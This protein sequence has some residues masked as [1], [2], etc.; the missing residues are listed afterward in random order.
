MD[1]RVSAVVAR[2]DA[3]DEQLG[4]SHVIQGLVK[5]GRTNRRIIVGLLISLALD[6]L[7]SIAVAII[8]VK[9]N[10]TASTAAS[11]KTQARQN[12]IAGN[13][14]RADQLKLW[15][16]V[17]SF[18]P[19]VNE[20]PAA[21][22]RRMAATVKFTAFIH[23]VFA[24]RDCDHLSRPAGTVPSTPPPPSPPAGAANPSPSPAAVATPTVVVVITTAPSH[25]A[26]G[27]P[28]SSPSPSESSSPT[29]TPTC[30]RVIVTA[31]LPP[32]A[33]GG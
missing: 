33:R 17:L 1:E 19:P 2:S 11:A 23:R 3:L 8:A 31:C 32:G 18:P 6:I 27:N 14:S 12:C 26:A 28:S 22:R 21:R 30:V 29:P 5:T 7:L 16:Y 10:D 4:V 15:T 25:V 24:P 13:A 9:A 20:T